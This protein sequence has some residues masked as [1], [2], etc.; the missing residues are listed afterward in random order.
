MIFGIFRHERAFKTVND[1]RSSTAL[2]AIYDF[3]TNTIVMV[4]AS[5]AE[6][7]LAPDSFLKCSEAARMLPENVKALFL[8]EYGL[9]KPLP[10]K[11]KPSEK[12]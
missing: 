1:R 12:K 2:E 3:D 4:R 9:G 5:Y 8:G 10:L 11:P 6:D 7:K